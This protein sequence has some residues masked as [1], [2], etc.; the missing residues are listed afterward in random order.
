MANIFGLAWLHQTVR[1]VLTKAQKESPAFS[2]VRF[3][4]PGA[5][6]CAI[7]AFDLACR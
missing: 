4:A 6:D 5:T 1:V 7:S 3:S 2:W